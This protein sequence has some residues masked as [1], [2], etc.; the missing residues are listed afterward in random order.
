MREERELAEAN[1]LES[2]VWETMQGTHDN[3][4]A[5]VQLVLDNVNENSIYMIASHNK[6]TVTLGKKLIRE[7]G[8]SNQNVRFGQLK[9][10]SDQLAN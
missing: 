6:D 1:G 3:Y 10:F 9:G 4:N 7:K 5:C 8:I 2:P